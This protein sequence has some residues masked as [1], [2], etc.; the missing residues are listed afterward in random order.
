LFTK[1]SYVCYDFDWA[2]HE[3]VI[4]PT[5]PPRARTTGMRDLHTKLKCHTVSESLYQ[6]ATKN[7]DSI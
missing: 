4:Q 1:H 5:K 6:G 3:T 2:E 7:E